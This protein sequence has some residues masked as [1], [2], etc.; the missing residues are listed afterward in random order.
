MNILN[1]KSDVTTSRQTDLELVQKE[2]QEYK[3]IDTFLRTP[4]L[5]LFCYN[6][7]KDIVEIIESKKSNSAIMVIKDTDIVVEDYEHSQCVIDPTCEFFEALNVKTAEKRVE[8]WKQG[9]IKLSNL[10]KYNSEGIKF[11]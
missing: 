8:K 4:G 11:Y 3:L 10:R 7:H 9:K 1:D 5:T 6:P 2:K